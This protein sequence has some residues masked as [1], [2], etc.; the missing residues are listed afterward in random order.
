MRRTEG[1]T[2]VSPT[3]R[4]PLLFIDGTRVRKSPYWEATERYGC[5]SYDIYN[6]MYIPGWFTDPLDE[7]WHLVDHVALWDVAAERCL[8]ITGPDAH[9]FTNMLTP[10]DLDR[11]A[12]GQGKYV[13]LTDENGGI[14]ND[15]VLLRLG[16]NHYWLA[17]ADSDALLWAKGVALNAGMDVEIRE[18]DAWPVQVQG[19]KSRDVMR[20]L[21]GDAILEVRYYWTMQTEIDGIPVLISR[22]GWSGE[23]GYEIY[24]REASRGADL[25]ERIMEAGR[26]F[27]IR[28]T[29]P[30][31]VR[32]MEAGI[33]NYGADMTLEN[34][35]LEVTGL[36]RMVEDKEADY[37]GKEALR[38]IKAEGVKRKLVGIELGGD[39]LTA[40]CQDPWPVLRDGRTVGRVTNAVHSPRL[41]KNIGY[42]WV[43]IELAD[44][45][46]E[47]AVETP[48]G[49]RPARVVPLPFLD[50]KKEI[51]RS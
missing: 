23:L 9:R 35:P 32:R 34:N 18:A 39:P 21:V 5:Q 1:G 12:V 33:F 49:L 28:P 8:E 47:L 22:T 36:E 29:G 7:Y 44:L 42:A 20:A 51:P 40:A 48:V 30:N 11:C 41:A 4:I 17:L 2:R 16:E 13:V 43:P 45:D 15:P 14:I 26:P 6:H 24:L 38:R 37:I 19:P 31:D 46:T 50:P 25:W 3:Q 27:N 10:R